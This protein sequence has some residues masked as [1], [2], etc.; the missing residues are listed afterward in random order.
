MGADHLEAKR[1]IGSS[2]WQRETKATRSWQRRSPVY[3]LAVEGGMDTE[4]TIG[5][6]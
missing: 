1:V 4:F 2:R 5:K 3:I 6:D